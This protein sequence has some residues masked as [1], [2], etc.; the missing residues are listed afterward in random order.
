[1][2]IRKLNIGILL[3]FVFILS[4]SNSFAQ[5]Q[6]SKMKEMKDKPEMA[7]MM[8]SP[9]HKLMMAY[10]QNL[11]TFAKTLRDAAKESENI[12][13]DF[14]K[15]IVAEIKRSSEMMDKIHKDHMESMDAAML[16]KMSSNM[17]KMKKDQDALKANISALEESVQKDSLNS[18]EIETRAE[19]IISQ[20]GKKDKMKMEKK[21]MMKKKKE[22]M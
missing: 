22:E 21:E 4:V 9:Q 7:E 20:L 12:D 3:V 14:A 17:D 15:S 16:E 5:D 6:K 19:A 11:L 10:R 1:M 2:K 8:K 13:A 18:K